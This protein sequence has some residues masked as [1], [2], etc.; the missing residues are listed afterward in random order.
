MRSAMARFLTVN[1]FSGSP[2]VPRGNQEF[3]LDPEQTA[4]DPESGVEPDSDAVGPNRAASS[5]LPTVSPPLAVAS[6]PRRAKIATIK[7]LA[8]TLARKV[9]AAAA[10]LSLT[11]FARATCPRSSASPGNPRIRPP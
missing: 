2:P 9:N 8:S 1:D 6:H 7:A 4:A 3:N 5:L 11:D 10:P